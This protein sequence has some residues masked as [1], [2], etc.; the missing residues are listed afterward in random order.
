MSIDL[1]AVRNV[2]VGLSAEVRE[3]LAAHLNQVLAD[4]M[5]IRDLYKKHH[6]QVS[7]PT[8][9]QLHVLFDKHYDE[10][11]ALVDQLG[12]RVQ[13]LG[14]TSLAMAHD[15]VERT[16]IPRPPYERE[17]VPAQ[18]TRLL[19]A[20]EIIIKEARKSARRAQE[21]GDDGSNDLLVSD[22]LRTNE[23]QVWFLSEHLI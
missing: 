5:V 10:Q 13:I 23:M 7:G 14:G 15:V 2:P 3:E 8:F 16:N 18:I 21:L 17:E 4:T 9:H 11:A 1:N 19:E 22:V 6:W 20:H 12:E